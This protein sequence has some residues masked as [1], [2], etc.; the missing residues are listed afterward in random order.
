MTSTRTL[1]NLNN[2]L[3]SKRGIVP[4]NFSTGN[5]RPKLCV[6]LV[7]SPNGY[8]QCG[9]ERVIGRHCRECY[10]E[11][12][13]KVHKRKMGLCLLVIRGNK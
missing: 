4:H 1:H 9:K 3:D 10:V 12:C 7:E 6:W 2:E 11:Y 8:N 13:R 5:L